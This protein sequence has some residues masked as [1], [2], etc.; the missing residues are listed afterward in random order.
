MLHNV[1]YIK[2]KH[3]HRMYIIKKILVTFRYDLKLRMQFE[4]LK[5][6]QYLS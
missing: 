6:Y 4:M 1:N 3:L 2:S 5:N